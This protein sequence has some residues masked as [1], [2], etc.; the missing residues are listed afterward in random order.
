MPYYIGNFNSPEYRSAKRLFTLNKFYTSGFL[1]HLLKSSAQTI[2]IFGS[3]SRWD[4]H[5]ESDLD[6]F[7]YGKENINLYAYS[8]KLGVTMQPFFCNNRK[9]LEKLGTKLIKNI[10]L[11]DVIKGN[12]DFIEVNI[13]ERQD[14]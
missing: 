1:D 7:I 10:I 6:I 12:L 4:W 14:S 9:D 3:Y 13:G 8:K 2:I 11:G 5:A